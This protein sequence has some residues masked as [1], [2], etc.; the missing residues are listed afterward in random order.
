M[1]AVEPA[2]MPWLAS[3]T[4]WAAPIASTVIITAA[5][6]KINAW[7]K[8]SDAKREKEQ[9]AT[10]A[11]RAAEKEWR[12]EVDKKLAD[13][14]QKIGDVNDK[15]NRQVALQAA[16]TR[17]DIIHKCHRYLDDLGC[18]SIEERDALI[19]EH[20]QYVQF[21]SDLGIDNE[22]INKLVQKVMDLPTREI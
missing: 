10:D 1:I 18:A 22:F 8:L 15:V 21:C 16:D 19:D 4:S 14:A 3:F 20:E 17:A 13:L 7:I 5:T 6:A 2:D 9:A 12:D 11:K